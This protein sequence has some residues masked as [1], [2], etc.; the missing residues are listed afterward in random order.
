[1]RVFLLLAQFVPHLKFL[2]SQVGLQGFLPSIPLAL[3]PELG[4][5]LNRFPA[6]LSV[7]RFK[8]RGET[9]EAWGS[10]QATL[11]SDLKESQKYTRT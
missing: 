6:L 4:A 2:P 9:A 10:S 11:S 8:N 5:S 1:M 3:Q 7:L